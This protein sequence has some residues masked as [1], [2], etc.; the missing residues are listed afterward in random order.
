[1][2]EQAK[3]LQPLIFLYLAIATWC[4]VMALGWLKW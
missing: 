1:M 2:R 3:P 4:F